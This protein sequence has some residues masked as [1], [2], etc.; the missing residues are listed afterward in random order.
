MTKKLKSVVASIARMEEAYIQEWVA[1]QYILGFD[2]IVVIIQQLQGEPLCHTIDKIQQLPK[3]VL[4]KVETQIILDTRTYDEKYTQQAFQEQAY[5]QLYNQIKGKF[6]WLASFDI[7]ELFYDSQQRSINKILS[8]VPKTTG[9]VFIPWIVYGHNNR[10]L[11][12]KYPETRLSAFTTEFGSVRPTWTRSYGKTITRVD[13]IQA[14]QQWYWCHEMTA[15]GDF[16]TFDGEPI[17]SEKNYKS[18]KDIYLAHYYTGSMEDWT[19]R[20]K[21]VANNG[22]GKKY[23][24]GD[25]MYHTCENQDTRMLIYNEKIK[26]ILSQCQK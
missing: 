2:K 25:F 1:H 22:D 20:C 9:Q 19:I 14:D 4:E 18:P 26:K 17:V 13:N 10:V 21:R 23:D 8:T 24:V 11:S 16:T 5:H 7:D 6:E 12:V 15:T 3:F